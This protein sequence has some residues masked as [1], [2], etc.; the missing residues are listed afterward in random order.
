[1]KATAS[2]GNEGGTAAGCQ[3]TLDGNVLPAADSFFARWLHHVST[4][5]V[6]STSAYL[7][8]RGRP[9]ISAYYLLSPYSLAVYRYKRMRLITRVYS[10]I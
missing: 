8:G 6:A 9:L 1:M 5:L 2:Q 4:D 7:G 3:R 10:I